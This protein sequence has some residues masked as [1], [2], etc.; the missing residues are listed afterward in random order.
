MKGWINY[1]MV[2]EA[3]NIPLLPPPKKKNNNNNN[4]TEKPD[5]NFDG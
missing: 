1:E 2:L 3:A 5:A 4:N